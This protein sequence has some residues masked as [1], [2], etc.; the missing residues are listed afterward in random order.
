M[1]H[2]NPMK[3]PFWSYSPSFPTLHMVLYYNSGLG[4]EPERDHSSP[5][6]VRSDSSASVDRRAFF[7][8][9]SFFNTAFLAFDYVIS[10][11]FGFSGTGIDRE[12][13]C[14]DWDWDSD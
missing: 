5:R 13:G 2:A 10:A 11:S 8:V 4:F 3:S 9:L 6:S 14:R 1:M 12:G 7:L